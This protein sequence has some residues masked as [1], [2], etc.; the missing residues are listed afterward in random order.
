MYQ[1]S[2]LGITRKFDDFTGIE[3]STFEQ[4]LRKFSFEPLFVGVQRKSTPTICGICA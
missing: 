2:L 3:N 1:V 4:D